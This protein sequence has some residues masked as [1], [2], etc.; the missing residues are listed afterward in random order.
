MAEASRSYE[1]NDIPRPKQRQYG[2]RPVRPDFTIRD[3][4]LKTLQAKRKEY[5]DLAKAKAV[6]IEALQSDAKA[7]NRLEQLKRGLAN[8]QH[9]RMQSQARVQRTLYAAARYA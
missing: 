9:S 6:E 4:K 3:E 2:K 5:D 1:E 7:S 8:A